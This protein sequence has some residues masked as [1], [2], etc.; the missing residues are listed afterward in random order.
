M[1]IP[2]RFDNGIKPHCINSVLA[3]IKMKIMLTGALEG[4]N[5]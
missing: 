2:L 5:C 4:A 3:L 1:I